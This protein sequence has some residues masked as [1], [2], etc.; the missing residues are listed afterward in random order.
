MIQQA[1]I[2]MSGYEIQA[3]IVAFIEA[4]QAPRPKQRLHQFA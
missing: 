4:D 3:L 2:T 1:E